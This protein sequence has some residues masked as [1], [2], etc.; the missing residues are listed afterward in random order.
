MRG[1][2]GTRTLLAVLTTAALVVGAVLVGYALVHRHAPGGGPGGASGGATSPRPAA[3]LTRSAPVRLLVPAIGVDA[4]VL[5]LGLNPDGTVQEPSLGQPHLTSWY[6]LGSAP[7]EKGPATFFGHIDT[8]A[9]GPA[10]FYRL[11]RLRPGDEVRVPRRDGITA[12]FQITSVEEV[13][14]SRFPTVRVYGDTPDSTIRL[15]SCGGEFDASTGHYRD[16]VIAYGVL[17]GSDHS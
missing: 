15:V 8:R 2:G 11:A 3:P 6:D 13:A 14:K 5:A 9:S 1:R 16:N 10:V 17:V 7:G 12:V 4:P